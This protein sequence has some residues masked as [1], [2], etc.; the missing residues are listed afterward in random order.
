MSPTSYQTAPPR[1]IWFCVSALF[2]DCSSIIPYNRGSVKVFS[3]KVLANFFKEKTPPALPGSARPGP[4]AKTAGAQRLPPDTKTAGAHTPAVCNRMFPGCF[5]CKDH[6]PRR[7]RRQTSTTASTTPAS[8]T[9]GQAMTS[10]TAS[11]CAPDT[12]PCH[13]SAKADP[14]RWTKFSAVGE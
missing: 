7:S 6:R 11:C 10:Q 9:T 8:S 14:S 5:C 4:D 2:A 13:P 12:K 3:K 1:D